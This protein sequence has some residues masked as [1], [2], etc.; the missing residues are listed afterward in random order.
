MST[1]TIVKGIMH[2]HDWVFGKTK[3]LSFVINHTISLCHFFCS[4]RPLNTIRIR[5]IL[6]S[7]IPILGCRIIQ[8]IERL[9]SSAV[10][11]FTLACIS[12]IIKDNLAHSMYSLLYFFFRHVSRHKQRGHLGG[13]PNGPSS[14]APLGRIITFASL[15]HVNHCHYA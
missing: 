14:M 2:P 4:F 8:V 15:K 11:R 7:F 12:R 6:S 10:Q 9:P 5:I 3:L 13:A 1:P